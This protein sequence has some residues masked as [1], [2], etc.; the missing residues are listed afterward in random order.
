MKNYSIMHYLSFSGRTNV[1]RNPL[2]RHYLVL[3][4]TEMRNLVDSVFHGI[5]RK[6]KSATLGRAETS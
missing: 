2:I 3:L 6:S 1:Y 5:L 4:I